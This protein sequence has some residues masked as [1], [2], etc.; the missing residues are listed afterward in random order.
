MARKQ[1]LIAIEGVIGSGKTTLARA[2][3]RHL[4]ATPLFEEMISNPFLPLFYRNRERHALACQLCF[5]EGRY[6]QFSRSYPGRTIVSDHSM[7]KDPLFAR[8]N[9]N[10]AERELYDRVFTHFRKSIVLEPAVIIYLSASLPEL[11]RRIRERKRPMESSIDEGYL[12]ALIDAYEATFRHPRR[13]ART[14]IVDADSASFAHD[15]KALQRL[16]EACQRAPVG[17][18]YCSPVL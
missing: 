1:H 7:D 5:L 14:V 9:L 2:L 4:N 18:S 6:G 12:G 10:E 15:A 17:V 13:S 8:I 3:A 16:V 11:Q